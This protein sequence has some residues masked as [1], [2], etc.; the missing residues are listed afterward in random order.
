M[1]NSQDPSFLQLIR[2]PAQVRQQE[3]L[4]DD[5]KAYLENLKINAYN[6]GMMKQTE[7]NEKLINTGLFE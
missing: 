5:M 6:Q 2:T 1:W 3:Q 4:K 7:Q